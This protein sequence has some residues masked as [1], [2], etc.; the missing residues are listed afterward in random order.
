VAGT[1]H[2][3]DGAMPIQAGITAS[4]VALETMALETMDL[5]QEQVAEATDTGLQRTILVIQLTSQLQR[6]QTI[7][8]ERLTLGTQAQEEGTLRDLRLQ[9][10]LMEANL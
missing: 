2:G 10:E 7:L 5:Q 9:E 8:Q 4:T 6:V 3:T 1:I